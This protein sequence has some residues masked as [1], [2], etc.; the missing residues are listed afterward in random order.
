MGRAETVITDAASTMQ[1]VDVQVFGFPLR[2]CSKTAAAEG[3][4]NLRVMARS[5]MTSSR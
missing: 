1:R 4:G 5:Q 2:D 3:E